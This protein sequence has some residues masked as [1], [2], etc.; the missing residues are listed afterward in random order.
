MKQIFV[1]IIV[2]YL[3]SIKQKTDAQPTGTS[4]TPKWQPFKCKAYS[5]DKKNKNLIDST[6]P[7][8]LQRKP[9]GNDELCFPPGTKSVYRN[10]MAPRIL[11]PK[12][13]IRILHYRKRMQRLFYAFL[14][15]NKQSLVDDAKNPITVFSVSKVG[16]SQKL[17]EAMYVPNTKEATIALKKSCKDGICLLQET[18]Q[19][20]RCFYVYE[21]G[22]PK[23]K[24]PEDIAKILNNPSTKSIYIKPLPFPDIFLNL[25]FP[26]YKDLKNPL[27][28]ESEEDCHCE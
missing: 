9:K 3:S 1:S 21:R 13:K 7:R 5:I 6:C 15:D 10:F 17:R 16:N 26:A 8:I 22:D 20:S 11:K 23:K 25:Y 18:L 14:N 24:I 4:T 12:N 28:L 2:F 27:I 19:R